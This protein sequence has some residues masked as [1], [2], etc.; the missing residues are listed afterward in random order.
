MPPA[1]LL[2]TLLPPPTGPM[3]AEIDKCNLTDLQ[4]LGAIPCASLSS[5]E[6]VFYGTFK[7]PLGQHKGLVLSQVGT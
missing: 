6:G 2:C 1:Y 4:G 7:T 5:S 3:L